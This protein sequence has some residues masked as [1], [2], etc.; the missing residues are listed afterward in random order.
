MQIVSKVTLAHLR[1]MQ[2]MDELLRANADGRTD[3][4]TL[5]Y[6]QIIGLIVSEKD[7][8]QMA[9]VAKAMPTTLAGND[10]APY[11]VLAATTE[12]EALIPFLEDPQGEAHREAH[13]AAKRLILTEDVPELVRGIL[14]F[15]GLFAPWFGNIRDY[16][17]ATQ[18]P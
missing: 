15:F 8:E 17:A 9:L 3:G 18:E 11:L 5:T 4:W 12:A 13:R 2:K 7:G 6:D 1:Y 16:L 14:D 10:L